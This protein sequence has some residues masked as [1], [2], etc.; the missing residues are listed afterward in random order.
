MRPIA[1]PTHNGQDALSLAGGEG[2]VN[3]NLNATL[4]VPAE[5]LRRI[6]D[7]DTLLFESTDELE[8]LDIPLGQER[9]L[10]ALRLST[11]M[12]RPGYNTFAYGPPGVGRHSTV[13]SF[14]RSEKQKDK[15]KTPDDWVFVFRFSDPSRPRA[16]RMP[17]TC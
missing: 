1:A 13:L 14:L 15:G 6:I 8:P 4:K 2:S 17:P 7:P 5:K 10:S 11:S 12:K 3:E 16:L 9:A